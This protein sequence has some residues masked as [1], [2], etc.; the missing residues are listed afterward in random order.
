MLDLHFVPTAE[1]QLNSKLSKRRNFSGEPNLKNQLTGG[2]SEFQIRTSGVSGKGTSWKQSSQSSSNSQSCPELIFNLRFMQS[3]NFR[4][5]LL[6]STAA[7]S[8]GLLVT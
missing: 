6:L 5:I 4:L 3:E 8:I 7:C 1:S 2:C